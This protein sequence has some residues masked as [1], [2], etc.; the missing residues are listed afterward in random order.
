MNSAY[1]TIIN[2]STAG[3]DVSVEVPKLYNIALC[4]T[5]Y[6][7]IIIYHDE[8]F[9]INACRAKSRI[10]ETQRVGGNDRP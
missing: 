5:H 2:E 9:C 10:R 8:H 7:H 1:D 6:T 4:D 3:A